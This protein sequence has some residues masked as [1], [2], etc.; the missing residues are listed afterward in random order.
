MTK[1]PLTR[2]HRVL[3]QL[4]ARAINGGYTFSLDDFVGVD[5]EAVLR[6]SVRQSV[7]GVAYDALESLPSELRPERPTL[8]KW[9]GYVF[10]LEGSYERYKLAIFSLADFYAANGYRMM[11]LK[12]YG[13]AS[14]YP[15]PSHRP[16]GDID[17]FL[18]RGGATSPFGQK[19][20]WKEAD[21]V[22]HEKLGV[23]IDNTHHHHSVF[24]YKRYSVEDHFDFINV[25]DHRSS[26]E[27][28]RR[29]KRMAAESY[30]VHPECPDL[31][32]PSDDFNALFLLKHC[33]GHFASTEINLRQVLDWLLFM[34]THHDSIDWKMLYDSLKEFGLMRFANILS[35]IGVNYLGMSSSEFYAMEK[36]EALNLRVLKDILS[37]EFKEREDG[38]LLSGLWVK[39]RRFWHNRWKHRLCYRDSF[40]SGF[41]WSAYAKLLKPSHFRV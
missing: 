19:D 18:G 15:V 39:P 30:K 5:W 38:T 10:Q 21:D 8:L 32:L 16:T 24:V 3:L 12:G 20:V 6:L 35:A 40:V 29:L 31:C 23:K 7:V 41:I 27:F 11:L 9:I 33:S 14:C 4:V 36:D 25:H 34:R 28:E 26:R 13:L 2:T 37:P 1:T 17:I 22:I